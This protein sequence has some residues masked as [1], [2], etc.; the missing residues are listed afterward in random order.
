MTELTIS[1]PPSLQGWIEARLALGEYTDASDY[2][3]DLIRRDRNQC[4]AV[5]FDEDVE[6]RVLVEEGI[7]S[8]VCEEEPEE[9]LRRVIAKLPVTHG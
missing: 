5:D 9:V 2:L 1:M 3:R 8:G 6:M 7:A 4:E